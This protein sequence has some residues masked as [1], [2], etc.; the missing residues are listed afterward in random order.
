MRLSGGQVLRTGAARMLV[1]EPELLVVDDL[2]SALDVETEATLWPA[3]WATRLG[4]R[5]P[6]RMGYL[7]AGAPDGVPCWLSPTGAPSWSGPTR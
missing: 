1:R 6:V 5:A 2:S 4:H 3:C 7:R